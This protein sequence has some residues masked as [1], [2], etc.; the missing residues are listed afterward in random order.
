MSDSGKENGRCFSGQKTKLGEHSESQFSRRVIPALPS[1]WGW[2][3]LL[4]VGD[5]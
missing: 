5:R 2:R 4:G 3:S 1:F